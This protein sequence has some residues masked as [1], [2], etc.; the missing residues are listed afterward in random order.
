MTIE[1]RITY[2]ETMDKVKDQQITELQVAVKELAKS[3][4]GGVNHEGNDSNE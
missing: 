1:E 4:E 2:L 3:L